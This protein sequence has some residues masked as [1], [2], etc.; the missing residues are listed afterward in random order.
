MSSVDHFEYPDLALTVDRGIVGQPSTVTLD[1][2][3]ADEEGQ[4]HDD[5]GNVRATATGGEPVQAA[6]HQTTGGAQTAGEHDG[7]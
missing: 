7:E 2:I 3:T 1:W 4:D 6:E 5:L